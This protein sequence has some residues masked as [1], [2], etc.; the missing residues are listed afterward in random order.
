V[1]A[2]N[3]VLYDGYRLSHLRRS[4]LHVLHTLRLKLHRLYFSPCLLQTCLYNIAYRQQIDQAEFKHYRSNM[5]SKSTFLGVPSDLLSTDAR[6]L[7]IRLYLV[8]SAIGVWSIFTA[9]RYAK[10]GTYRRRVSVRP[11]VCLCLSHSGIVWKLL[12]L[13]SR[14]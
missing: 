9:R 2:I 10:R 12:N 6:C 7:V 13:G 8:G 5:R 11:S 1:T 3:R 14:K 4:T